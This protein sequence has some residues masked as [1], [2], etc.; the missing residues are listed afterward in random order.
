MVR[1]SQ[2]RSRN[3]M[4]R[5][6]ASYKPCGQWILL[7]LGLA[8]APASRAQTVRWG[9][10]RMNLGFQVGVEY[11]DNVNTSETNP[12]SDISLNLGPTIS[13][14]A[15][16][17][18]LF[19]GGQRFTLSLS[20]SYRKSLTGNQSDSFGAPISAVL[21]LPFYIVGWD[22]ALSDG[23]SFSNDPLETTFAVNRTK[24]DQYNNMVALNVS[25]RFGQ[26]GL[27]F[28]A[29]RGD[30]IYPNDPFLEQT[31][32]SFSIT[33]SLYLREGFSVFLA[34]TYG[35]YYPTDPARA[36]SSGYTSSIGVAGQIT[37]NLFGSI[38]VGYAHSTIDAV[39]TNAAQN[40]DGI[41]STMAITYAQGLRPNTSHTISLFRSPG[42]TAALQDANV[43][44]VTGIAY[45][46]S[47]RLNAHLTLSP[48]IQWTHLQSLSG[49]PQE[50]TDIVGFGINLNRTFTSHLNGSIGYLYQSRT[51][52]LPLN[53]Y[54][55]NRVTANL[56]YTF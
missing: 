29:S 50:T 18:V 53:S 54:D 15:E 39:G 27:A 41:S 35:L 2:A 8:L 43:T 40:I 21:E 32:Y 44:E 37:P 31:T 12:K 16:M 1:F 9:P 47:H 26:T 34:N 48:S 23:F 25:R 38:S 56:N 20:A 28:A 22:V 5:R 33:P 49:T 10:F 45:T 42:V 36:S 51:S 11:T 52:N 19:S 4:K 3:G 6:F 24:V 17:P 30:Q 7:I 13:G 46:I 14:G 55:V